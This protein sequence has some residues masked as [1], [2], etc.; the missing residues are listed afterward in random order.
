M[1]LIA[2]VEFLGFQRVITNTQSVDVP[3]SETSRA[4]DALEYIRRKYP[5]LYLEDDVII[6]VNNEV[7]SPDSI[8]KANDIILFLPVIGGG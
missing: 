2:S 3:I 8:L 1:K 5:E 4:R 7:A 6:T